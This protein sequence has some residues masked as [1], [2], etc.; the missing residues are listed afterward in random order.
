MEDVM[1]EIERRLDEINYFINNPVSKDFDDKLN[2]ILNKF[3]T[4]N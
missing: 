2:E 1:I 3:P 4:A